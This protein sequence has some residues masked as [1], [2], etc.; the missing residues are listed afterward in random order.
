MAR[1]KPIDT[2]PRFLSFDWQRQLPLR[3]FEHTFNYLNDQELDLSSFDTQFKNN[4]AG[5]PAYPSAMRLK[6][7]L[8]AV[9]Q[10]TVPAEAE[11]ACRDH[12]TF[13]AL[14]DDTQP[15][16]TTISRFVSNLSDDIARACPHG[17]LGVV[18]LSTF[19]R[20][21]PNGCRHR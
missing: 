7:I 12:V 14:S 4:E 15:Y 2:C 10:D 20:L 17:C 18:A 3:P 16:F 11:A 8:F 13:I 9:S 5:A 1:Y 21:L 6:V 19:V